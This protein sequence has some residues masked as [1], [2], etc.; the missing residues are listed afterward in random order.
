ML[1][2]VDL[3]RTFRQIHLKYRLAL[4]PYLSSTI[5][6]FPDLMTA[7]LVDFPLNFIFSRE[8]VNDSIILATKIE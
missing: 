3:C 5:S 8:S 2:S 1:G 4:R 6:R 7:H